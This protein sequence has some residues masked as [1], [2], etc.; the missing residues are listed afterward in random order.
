MPIYSAIIVALTPNANLLQPQ[1]WP[2]FF[3]VSNFFNSFRFIA[4]GLYNSFFYAIIATLLN[5]AVAVPAAYALAKY[6][7]RAKPAVMFCLLLT[8]MMA[9]IVIL[10]TLYTYFNKFGL[11]N[12]RLGTIITLTGVNLAL[13]VWIL[14]GYFR[15]LPIEIEEAALLDGATYLNLLLRIIIPISKSGIAV[16]AIFAFI[17]T[18]NEFVIP[19]FMLTD[20][21]QYPLTLLFYT[22][23]TDTSTR[24]HIMSAGSLIAIIPPIL[25]FTF[26]QKYIVQGLT[27]G[28]VK[29]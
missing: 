24:W 17:N 9:G 23:L 11:L 27:T 20:T 12:N 16:G 2:H 29:S 7:F 8:Q 10:P 28:A 1:L 19:L 4:H 3:E 22:L 18:Y 26:F 15:T 25:I 21:K 14:Y 13:V 6:P 5:I